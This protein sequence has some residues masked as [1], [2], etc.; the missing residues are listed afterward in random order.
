MSTTIN[1]LT[2]LDTQAI[3]N[4]PGI[5]A[6]DAVYMVDDNASGGSTDEGG[7]EL[8]TACAEGDVIVW[9]VVPINDTDEVV[10]TALTNKSGDLFGGTPP[11][12]QEDGS[13]QGTISTSGKET[14]ELAILING[15]IAYNWDPYL[16]AS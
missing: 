6:S 10:I 1:V 11:T 4:N 14:Y 3:L 8:N 5:S 13:W 15:V 7:Y 9:R 12:E 2:C 16:T